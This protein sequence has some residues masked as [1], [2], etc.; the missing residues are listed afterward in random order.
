MHNHTRDH[1]RKVQEKHP[2]INTSQASWDDSTIGKAYKAL[3]WD[4]IRSNFKIDSSRS[5]FIPS[6]SN[7]KLICN[8]TENIQT[9]I[10][11]IDMFVPNTDMYYRIKALLDTGAKGGN[12]VHPKVVNQLGLNIIRSS[13]VVCSA[14]ENS[15]CAESQ[16]F[17]NLNLN[18]FDE[19]TKSFMPLNIRATI[20][21][22]AYDLIIG[23]ATLREHALLEKVPGQFWE[24]KVCSCNPRGERLTECSE[25]K[26]S[27]CA[28]HDVHHSQVKSN[29]DTTLLTQQI[30]ASLTEMAN[31]LNETIDDSDDELSDNFPDL[32]WDQSN[33]TTTDPASLIPSH[34]EGDADFRQRQI[35]L[36]TEFSD[37]F[38]REARSEPADLPPMELNVDVEKWNVSKHRQPPRPQSLKAQEAI[39]K[40]VTFMESKNIIQS[41]DKAQA[42]S[43][44]LMVPKPNGDYRCCQDVR[45]LN[46]L[47]TT[48]SWPIPNIEQTIIRIGNKKAQYYAVMD[49]AAGY[50]QAPLH[51]NSKIFTAF[52]CFMGLFTWNRV[53]MG[54]KKAPGY[55]QRMMTTVVLVGLIYIICEAYLDDIITFGTTQDEYLANLRQ[56][57]LRF[58]KHGVAVH[59]DKTHLGL[60]KVEWAGHLFTPL[61][62]TYTRDRINAA[63]GVKQ[64]RLARELKAFLGLANYFHRFIRNLSH[65]VKILESLIPNYTKNSV[66]VLN[67]TTEATA[68]YQY[69]LEQIK[70]CPTLYF[71]SEYGEIVLETDASDFGIGAY[72]YQ[73]VDGEQRPISF[74]SK[75]LT[76]QQMHWSPYEKEGYAIYYA[77]RR[78]EYLLRDVKFRLKTDHKNLTFITT[79]ASPKVL[80]WKM[81]MQTYDYT[82]EYFKGA[83]NTT[84]DAFSRLCTLDNS[85]KV[86]EDYAELPIVKSLSRLCGLNN[87]ILEEEEEELSPAERLTTSQLHSNTSEEDLK[88]PSDL[89]KCISSVHNSSVGHFGVEMTYQRL[90][91]SEKFKQLNSSIKHPYLTIRKFVRVFRKSCPCCQKMDEIKVPIT[92]KAFTTAS[93]KPMRRLNIDAIGPLPLSKDGFLHILVI[94]DT[95]TRFIELYPIKDVTAKS[96]AKAILQHAGRYGVADQILSDRGP[97]FVNAIIQE[98]LDMLQSDQQF[99][100]AYSKEENAIVERSNKE[101]M[102]HL[103]AIIFDKIVIDEWEDSLPLV[104]RIINSKVH[105]TTGVSPAQLLFGNAIDLDDQLLHEPSTVLKT[106]VS[107]WA[108]KM[109]SKQKQIISLAQQLQAKQDEQHMS[110]ANMKVDDDAI[111]LF[112]VN[113]FVLVEYPNRP[114]H[115][116]SL[117]NAGPFRVLKHIGSTY[118]LLNLVTNKKK[119]GVKI[120]F[121]R[122]Y[123]EDGVHDPRV[124]ANTDVQAY[125]VEKIISHTGSKKSEMKFLVK[126]LGYTDA[127]NSEVPWKDLSSNVHLHRYL[128]SKNMKNM[129]P[130]SYIYL[131]S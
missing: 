95:F 99:T 89:Y 122:P 104:Q 42:W 72:L 60:S 114:K 41:T 115:K 38:S 43:Q 102:R 98:F 81:E 17:V 124:V 111:D 7:Y 50:H 20:L 19:T 105:L 88:I 93:F 28:C 130:K 116:L 68:S 53:T 45:A 78:L 59:P 127:Y 103:R 35:D 2:D 110:S 71:L 26:D 109:L 113:S 76:S 119:P 129:I 64:P 36:C 57:F 13:S 18:Y 49:L 16:G 51:D 15:S 29:I 126:W 22:I 80:R 73:I 40:Q 123:I 108:D 87:I 5:K 70:N 12:F 65:H 83:D 92:T 30:I 79:S 67:W 100:T 14:F 48:E 4:T 34:I 118:T 62:H 47:T 120:Q 61:G 75:A 90:L 1:C 106:S 101:V 25:M 44:L 27:K 11:T 3:G 46:E 55:F 52:I 91:N 94:I 69:I 97:Q 128:I 39:H 112:P 121:L 117:Q 85:T 77:L 23:K 56:I 31:V 131:Y 82:V 74:I 107:Q 66:K 84:A 24:G 6:K 63:L 21:D 32:Y 33:R 58:R 54:L 10:D 86:E 8:L 96:A 125:D 9:D 37:I